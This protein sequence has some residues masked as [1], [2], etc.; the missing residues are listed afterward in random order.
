MKGLDRRLSRPCRIHPLAASD[1]DGRLGDGRGRGVPADSIGFVRAGMT[2]G[3]VE[4]SQVLRELQKVLNYEA[5]LEGETFV[6]WEP[7]V[8]RIATAP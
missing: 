2:W 3:L 6:P 8:V 5:S 4:R 7:F 1:R